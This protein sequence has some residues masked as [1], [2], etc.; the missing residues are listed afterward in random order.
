MAAALLMMTQCR[1]ENA[2]PN[3]PA[4]GTV[5]M[6]ITA[7]PGRTDINTATGAI[8][9][10]AG[11]KLYVSDGTNWLG[12]LTLVGEGGSAQGTFTGSIAA[13]GEGVT[14]CHFFYLGH[15]NGMTEPAGTAAVNISFAAQD[16]TR[17]GA[18]KYH[19]GHGS[20]NVTEQDGGYAG[21]VEMDT[22]IAIAHFNFTTDGT[23]AYNGSVTMGGTGIFNTLSVNPNGTFTGSGDE[24]I[25]IGNGGGTTGE[26]YVTL[27][28]SESPI[29][30]V[31]FT[32]DATGSM[33]FAKGIHENK[34][35]GM[36]EAIEVTLAR[37]NVTGVTLSKTSLSLEEG[38]T[39][40]LVATVTP[41]NATYKDVTWSST[42]TSVATV[43]QNG[44]VT[45]V[46]A[47]TATITVTTTDGGKTATCTVTVTAAPY[48][49]FGLPSGRLWA[50]CNLGAST[51]EDYGDYYQW[52]G[53]TSV[54]STGINLGWAGCPFTKGLYYNDHKNV[55]TKYV[56]TGMTE[57][58]AGSG[59][60]D[61]KLVLD[62]ADDAAH[63]NLGGDW[64]MPTIEE[65][66]E[67][68]DNTTSEWTMENGVN[69]YKLTSKTDQQVH[70]PPGC[71]PPRRHERGPSGFQWLLLVEF[72]P[73]VQ[74]LQRVHLVVPFG[75]YRFA[76][77]K[78]P[79]LRVPCA[80]CAVVLAGFPVPTGGG[81]QDI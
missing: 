80:S 62:P 35:Y 74:A 33:T 54:T 55:F 63:V 14:T 40:T 69:G 60:P 13:V 6:T 72:G 41:D 50:T 9:W 64:R 42:K 71:R 37:V 28:P 34:F 44:V 7:G 32:G 78:L 24:G 52:G 21:Y 67:L 12:S 61:N 4:D 25:T 76:E 18:M 16:G 15:D 46:G 65:W 73:P 11:D 56:P 43:D 29:V 47:G 38:K 77:Q 36:S 30:D 8:T 53:V 66:E 26:R 17:A 5:K 51:P 45:A 57:Y 27:I 10:S 70:L 39:E 22:K 68:Y 3:M 19:T 58:W 75:L 31:A 59:D 23:S 79:V 1:K 81:G 49:D 48:V 20:T 2:T